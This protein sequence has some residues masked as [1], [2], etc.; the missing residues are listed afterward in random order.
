MPDVVDSTKTERDCC[1]HSAPTS[2]HYARRRGCSHFAPMRS[3]GPASNRMKDDVATD[4]LEVAVE[5]L[6]HEI[7]GCRAWP[8]R[9]HLITQRSIGL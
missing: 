6:S 3:L 2:K 5:R 1:L 8:F 4:N 9:T 7:R